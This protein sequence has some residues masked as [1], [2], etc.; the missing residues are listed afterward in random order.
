[1]K[2]PS[3]YSDIKKGRDSSLLNTVKTKP[4]VLHLIRCHTITLWLPHK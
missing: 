2:E 3:T 1:M 4:A